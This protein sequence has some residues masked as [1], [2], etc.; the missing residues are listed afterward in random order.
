V[1]KTLAASA[2]THSTATL[3]GSANAK[4][5]PRNVFFDYGLTA[6]LGTT[7]AATPGVVSGSADTPVSASLT[8]LLPHTKYHYRLRASGA[9]GT[10]T[11]STMT[12]TTANRTPVATGEIIPVLPGA[13]VLLHILMNDND[14]DGDALSVASFTA[15]SPASAG[16]LVKQG[17]GLLFTASNTFTGASFNYV[18]KD[19]L[20]STSA[21]VTVNL[22]PGSCSIDPTTLSLS[23]GGASYD[24]AVTAT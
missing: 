20:G 2:I 6:A 12:F 23:A 14:P 15:L 19:P 3:N 16:K 1:A 4:G 17:S 7:I 13:T 24:I 9:L 22:S 5:T 18:A 8:D 21:S 10:A 11:G